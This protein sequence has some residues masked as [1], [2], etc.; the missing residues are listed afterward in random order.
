VPK[1]FDE[2]QEALQEQ[3]DQFSG[4]ERVAVRGVLGQKPDLGGE[5][6]GRGGW[7][8]GHVG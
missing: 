2:R 3:R 7:G 8:V 1:A 6:L 4:A 5:P